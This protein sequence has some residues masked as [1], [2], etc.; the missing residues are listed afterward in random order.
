MNCLREVVVAV[1]PCVVKVQN[2][3][4]QGNRD[5]PRNAR[6]IVCRATILYVRCL[7]QIL[8]ETRLGQVHYR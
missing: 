7:V 2:R 1:V 8:L 5:G 6:V 4:T 3:V